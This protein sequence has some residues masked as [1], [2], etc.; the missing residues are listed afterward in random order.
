MRLLE[1]Y[2][3]AP[4]TD[5]TKRPEFYI[6]M[7]NRDAIDVLISKEYHEVDLG[8]SITDPTERSVRQDL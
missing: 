5:P 7:V 6:I 8:R 2:V 1:W 4:G 3:S